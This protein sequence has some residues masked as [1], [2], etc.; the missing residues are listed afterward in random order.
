MPLKPSYGPH[1]GIT[2]YHGNCREILP[3]LQFDVLLTDPPYGISHPTN[4]A[5]RAVAISPYAPTLRQ[6]SRMIGR[7]TLC[8]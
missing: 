1:A 6:F 5:E 8:T 7:L 2:I 3:S 4:Y